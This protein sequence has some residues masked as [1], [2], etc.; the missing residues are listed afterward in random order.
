MRTHWYIGLGALTLIACSPQA[1]PQDSFLANLKTLCGKAYA[2]TLV[3]DDPQDDGFAREM[4]TM[5]VRDCEADIVRIPLHV[6]D[7]RSR[8]WIITRTDT[9]LRLK[10]DHRHEDGSED[11]VTQYGG[12]TNKKGSAKR[13]E[14][15]ADAFSKELFE[16]EGLAVSIDNIW[17]MEVAPGKVFAYE[18]RRPNRF[19]RI[20]FDLTNPVTLPPPAWGYEEGAE[21]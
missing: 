15:P 17:A 11:V 1:E 21:E 10:H 18:L 20:E 13:Q 7:N 12:D 19:F 8:T 2:G 9:G 4:I 16:R 5:H 14:F 6:G 3:S